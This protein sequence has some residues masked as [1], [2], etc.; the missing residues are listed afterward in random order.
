MTSEGSSSSGGDNPLE[1]R[2]ASWVQVVLQPYLKRYPRN[3]HKEPKQIHDPIGRVIELQPWEIYVLDSP[4]MQ[5]LRYIRQLG[6]G[7]FLFPSSGYSRF[8]HSLGALETANQ[9]FEYVRQ[10]P[11]PGRA[12]AGPIYKDEGFTARRDVV[13]LA[14]L[15]HDVGHCVFSHVSERFYG[16]HPEVQ[17]LQSQFSTHYKTHLTPSEVLSLLILKSEPFL[18]LL[19]AAM[20]RRLEYAEAEIA[21]LVCS[22]VAGSKHSLVPDC[23]MAEIVNGPVDCDKLDY[24]ARD[25]HMAGVPISLDIDRL[26]SKL[27][28]VRT[29][30]DDDRE[31]FSIAVVPSGTRALDE[32]LVSRIFMYD[33]FYYHP[34]IMAAEELIRR[35]L[36]TLKKA[37]PVLQDPAVLLPF[38]DDDFLAHTPQTLKARFGKEQDVAA[39]TTGCELLRRTRSR[40]LPKRAFAVARRYLPELPDLAARFETGGKEDPIPLGLYEFLTLCAFSKR[41]SPFSLNSAPFS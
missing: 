37:F 17:A 20:P 21:H 35:A 4:L 9:M 34:K 15:L 13:R 23:F 38:G 31:V 22:C 10:A 14:A 41:C 16:R 5:R 32:L 2:V 8:E 12:S 28:L 1:R 25:A 18:A 36:H 27:R 33:K 6:V 11:V 26:L 7:Q 40:D 3:P 24:L 19:T 29:K 39:L 30:G